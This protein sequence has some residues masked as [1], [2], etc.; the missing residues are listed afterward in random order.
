MTKLRIVLALLV[1][2]VLPVAAEA[3]S[4]GCLPNPFP[5]TPVPPVFAQNVSW[6]F[7]SSPDRLRFE[8]WRESCLD[9]SGAA[10]LLRV[11]PISPGPAYFCD[12]NLQIIQ[13][14]Q[15]FNTVDAK[16][17]LTDP[18]YC[19]GVYTPSATFALQVEPS[20]GIPFNESQAFTL[21]GVGGPRSFQMEIP[22]SA[23]SPSL[24]LQ[25]LGCTTCHPGD[26]LGFQVRI[27]NPGPPMLV[28]LNTSA[29]LRD[30][31]VVTIQDGEGL[32]P[33][34]VTVIP[35]FTGLVL[36]GGIPQGTYIIEAVLLDPDLDEPISED[37]E[38]LTVAP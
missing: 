3:F 15:Q 28:E 16:L 13:G 24:T 6:G 12:D 25:A 14:G 4:D 1:A 31:S 9:G 23:S 30:G 7:G 5:T 37:S 11:T 8:I 2:L 36:P 32:L 26:T 10:L 17:L 35:V 29:R 22:A 18:G 20:G 38:A 19:G 33:S 34:G 21:V 27:V